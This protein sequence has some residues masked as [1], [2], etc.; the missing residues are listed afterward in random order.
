MQ[1]QRRWHTKRNSAGVLTLLLGAA[2][3]TLA[4]VPAMDA[5]S[6]VRFPPRP[7]S[8]MPP[9]EVAPPPAPMPAPEPTPRTKPKSK[10]AAAPATEPAPATVTRVEP[11]VQPQESWVRFPIL[12]NRPNPAVAMPAPPAATEATPSRASIAAPL[13][14]GT[15]NPPA[16]AAMPPSPASPVEAVTAQ[17]APK[18]RR[19]VDFTVTGN[20][21]VPSAD[22]LA[23]VTHQRG[24]D[25]NNDNLGQVTDSINDLYQ[26]KG[27]LAL[28]EMPE[29]DLSSGVVQIKVTEAKFAGLVVED[30]K[31]Q[32]ANNPKLPVAMVERLQPKGELISLPALDQASALMNEIPGVEIKTSLRPGE[33]PGETQAVALIDKG[34]TVE[35]SVGIDD[36]GAK[37]TGEIRESA[38]LTV[39]NPLKMGDSATVQLLHSQG[40]DYQRASYSVPVGSAG[41]RAGVNTSNS[42]Y[43]VVAPEFVYLNARGPSHTLGVDLTIPLVRDAQ[44]SWTLQLG[45]D[46]RKYKNEALDTVQ[47]DY[48]GSTVSA[49]LEGTLRDGAK[50]ETTTSLQLVGGHIDLSGSTPIHRYGDAIT[51]Q[52]EGSYT[53]ARFSLL[54]RRDLDAQN[55]LLASAQT[56]WASKNLDSSEKFFL[57]GANG[58]RAYP[59]NEAGGTLGQ[60]ASLEWQRHFNW[61][62][63]RVTAAGF[64][65]TGRITINKYNNFTNAPTKNSY[66]LSG[67]G[68]WLGT[69]IP[70]RYGLTTMRFT[71]AHRLGTNE[72]ATTAGLD[73]DGTRVLNRYRFSLTQTF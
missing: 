48:R 58:V 25:L 52:T 62:Q 67:A 12:P 30:P 45:A 37:A 44:D 31:G 51:T 22:I 32:L 3:Q 6:W 57:G 4:Q 49:Y 29:Q 15:T 70:N 65:D 5:D 27:I 54:H 18:Q 34:K 41:W 61:D 59:T 43:K 17:S 2:V 23:L 13:S 50:A 10:A 9:L 73:Q 1:V 11:V 42:T 72:G 63:R 55:T 28:V 68:F 47:S 46:Q 8:A 26:R 66:G 40:M 35:G 36:A 39:H 19:I 56:Q 20:E 69:S 60:L 71:A 33:K 21:R 64:Y 38:R 7:R 24:Q 53:K 16:A 14:A